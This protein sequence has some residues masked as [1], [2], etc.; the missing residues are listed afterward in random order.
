MIDCVPSDRT[1]QLD[2]N[3]VI[4]I[5]SEIAWNNLHPVLQYVVEVRDPTPI[6]DNTGILW[7]WHHEPAGLQESN[8]EFQHQSFESGG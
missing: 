3:E 7:H 8:N 1:T 2:C 4:T 6:S 5:W